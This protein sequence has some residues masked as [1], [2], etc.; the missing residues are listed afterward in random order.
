MP[1]HSL[2]KYLFAV[3]CKLGF[4][5]W[6]FIDDKNLVAVLEKLKPKTADIRPGEAMVAL[7]TESTLAEGRWSVH[8]FRWFLSEYRLRV[9]SVRNFFQEE[10]RNVDFFV[11]RS[12]FEN[13]VKAKKIYLQVNFAYCCHFVITVPDNCSYLL[14][15]DIPVG[16]LKICPKIF[17]ISRVG[18][19]PFNLHLSQTFPNHILRSPDLVAMFPI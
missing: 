10:A 3:F 13:S 9:A 12:V 4:K 18:L 19:G 7:G 8:S 15:K 2:N 6:G 17:E 11:K 16:L 1:L 14:L 5:D